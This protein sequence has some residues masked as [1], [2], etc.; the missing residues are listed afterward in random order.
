MTAKAII[1]ESSV[2]YIQRLQIDKL[3]NILTSAES[4]FLTISRIDKEC[5]IDRYKAIKICLSAVIIEEKVDNKESKVIALKKAI[6]LLSLHKDQITP[7]SG[8]TGISII[9]IIST[10][11]QILNRILIELIAPIINID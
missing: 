10:L 2:T 3:L 5:S 7:A 6:E 9:Y 11:L 8:A 1:T 4:Q